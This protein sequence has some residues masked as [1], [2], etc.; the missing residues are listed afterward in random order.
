MSS[1]SKAYY[2]TV[3]SV[4]RETPM[5]EFSDVRA[6]RV[7]NKA[8]SKSDC[9]TS[10]PRKDL[11]TDEYD[12]HLGSRNPIQMAVCPHCAREHV[13]TR[14]RT[15]PTLTTW[16]C[17]GVGIAVFFPIAWIPLVVDNM[18]TTDHFCQDCGKKIGTLKPM[19]N[20]CVKEQ[21]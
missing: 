14:T 1:D 5:V 12:I 20:V 19:E 7:D 17:V 6:T 9:S 11:Y 16:V 4:E 18:K 21:F 8:G 3:A 15:Y 2:T 10:S 13:N